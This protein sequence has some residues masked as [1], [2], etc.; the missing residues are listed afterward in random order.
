MARMLAGQRGLFW[1]AKEIR[2]AR[3]GIYVWECAKVY[4]LKW[5]IFI[6]QFLVSDKLR[7]FKCNSPTWVENY[8]RVYTARNGIHKH[9][10]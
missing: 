3:A 5:S 7:E 9:L 4:G 8:V 2:E 6:R 10:F 1:L